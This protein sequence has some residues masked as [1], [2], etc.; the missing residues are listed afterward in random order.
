MAI[1]GGVIIGLIGLAILVV[2]HELGHAWQARRCNVVVE[3]FGIGLPPTAWKKKLKNGVTFSINWLMLGGFVKLQGEYDEANK[4]GDYGAATFWQKTRI[5][6]AGVF[7]NTIFAVVIISILSVFGLPKVIDN[8]FMVKN[9]ATIV[10][11]PVVITSVVN[12]SSAKKS[13]LMADDII[14]NFAGAKVTSDDQLVALINKNKGLQVSYSYLRNNKQYNAIAKL[15]TDQTAGYFGVGISQKEYIRSTWSAPVV[16][17]VT[18]AQFTWETAKGVGTLLS[19][20]VGNTILSFNPSKTVRT[21]ASAKLKSVGDNVAGPVGIVGTIFPAAE[22]S[23]P[24]QVAMLLAVI[25]VSL[26]VM[27]VIP[28]PSLDGGRWLTMAIFRL[29]KKKLTMEKEDKIQTFGFLVM[30]G[31]AILVT[32]LDVKKIL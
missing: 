18:T 7:V 20:L 17:V 14:T 13:G 30:M 4:K 19:D 6:F 25:S 16:G 8:Q 1:A 28:I 15:G 5:L 9:D 23:G 21:A 22:K 3:E 27:N 26:A 10:R 11:K 31:I 29:L 12:D 24:T 32:I 2:L